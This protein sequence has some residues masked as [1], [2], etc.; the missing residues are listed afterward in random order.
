MP[1]VAA[2]QN[3]KSLQVQSS[4]SLLISYQG[5]L[6]NSDGSPVVDGN[7]TLV[8]SLYDQE[9]GGTALWQETQN[10]ETDNGVFSST[11]G[12]VN[13]IDTLTFNRPFYLGIQVD[14]SEELSPR[15]MLTTVPYAQ[16]AHSIDDGTIT[17]SKLT[18]DAV[19]SSNIQRRAITS[20]KLDYGAVDSA[21]I[22]P[23]AVFKTLRPTLA[24][25]LQ[26]NFVGINRSAPITGSDKFVVHSSVEFDDTFGGMYTNTEGTNSWPFYGYA[27]GGES[28]AWHYFDFENEEWILEFDFLSPRHRIVADADGLKPGGDGDLMLGSSSQRWSAVY[29]ANGTIQTSDRRLKSNIEELDYG[30]QDILKLKPV[31]YTWTN[32][33]NDAPGETEQ[34][35]GLLAQDVEKVISEVVKEPKDDGYLGMNY[36]E[37]VPVLIQAIQEQQEHIQTLQQKLRQSESLQTAKLENLQAQINQLASEIQDNEQETNER[38]AVSE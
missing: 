31:G 26:D 3:E 6:T 32:E 13:S 17:T 29:A 20:E 38:S 15:T 11:L 2:Q 34:H 5:R 37:L 10:I 30:L 25:D 27:T 8:F 14:G 22:D 28:H 36:S 4:H 9:S 21:S 19:S 23:D 1:K 33:N 18:E 16:R 35:L 24:F 7:H 12:A